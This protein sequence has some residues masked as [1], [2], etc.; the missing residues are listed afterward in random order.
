MRLNGAGAI[1]ACPSRPTGSC[2]RLA[3]LSCPRGITEALSADVV[4]GRSRHVGPHSRQTVTRGRRAFVRRSA[5][6]RPGDASSD[7]MISGFAAWRMTRA[8]ERTLR[9]V[10]IRS[11]IKDVATRYD[12]PENLVAAIVE[13]ESQFNPRAVSPRGAQ[14]LMQLMPATAA[15]LGVGDPFDPRGNIEGGVRHLRS[16]MDRFDNNLPLVLAAYNAGEHAVIA[17]RGVPPYRRTRQYV[18]RILRQLDRDGAKTSR[19]GRVIA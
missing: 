2:A 8:D 17:H 15:T 19:P 9:S 4:R 10:D 18:K 16:L 13:I 1:D 3:G 14:G 11:H 6:A 5:R 7:A 12:V